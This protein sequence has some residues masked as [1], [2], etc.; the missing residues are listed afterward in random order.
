MFTLFKNIRK[1][2]LTRFKKIH[3][4]QFGEDIILKHLLGKQSK[5]FYV[6]V[7]CYHP[8]KF[9][10]TYFLYKKG[11]HGINI[12]MEQHKIDLFKIARKKD[13]NIHAAISDQSEKYYIQSNKSHDLF[14]ALSK[15]N[16]NNTPIHTQTL[17]DILN[18]TR[19]KNQ[20][21]DLLTVDAEGHDFKV[22][23]SLDFATYQPKIV[24]VESHLT[25]MREILKSEMHQ[26]M[27]DKG[28]CMRSWVLYSVVYQNTG[29]F[30]RPAT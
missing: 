15:D 9:S 19:Y 12:D 24:I 13:I 20:Q 3:Y 27:I 1:A 21:I 4:S 26:F 22:L 2:L 14:A 18:S 11:W 16:T 25:D 6:D 5:G 10:N 17:T 30:R 8:K 28:Y 23:K 7:G 29:Q